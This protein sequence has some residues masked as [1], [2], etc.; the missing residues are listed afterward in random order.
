MG[1]SL[2]TRAGLDTFLLYPSHFPGSIFKDS[3]T[4]RDM[5]LHGH[6]GIGKNGVTR[7]LFVL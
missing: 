6:P 1:H 2:S 3:H 5:G 7:S 4:W